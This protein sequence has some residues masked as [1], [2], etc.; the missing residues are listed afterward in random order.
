MTLSDL[1]PST[2]AD[3]IKKTGRA[4][5]SVYGELVHLEAC[6]Q[7][8]VRPVWSGKRLVEYEWHLAPGASVDNLRAW[9]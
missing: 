5:E 8:E 1:L 6:G 2:A 9:A 7:V 4:H 3:L